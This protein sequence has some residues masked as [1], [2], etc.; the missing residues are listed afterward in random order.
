ML[1]FEHDLY[2][3][4]QMLQVLTALE[5]LELEPGRV[6]VVQ[7]DHYLANMTVD[8]IIPLLPKRRTA[9]AAIFQSARRNWERFTSSSPARSLR[10][11]GRRRDRAAASCAPRCSG[12]AR[13][14][15][16]RATGCRDRSVRRSMP[17]TRGRR[18]RKSCSRARRRAKRRFFLASAIFER[19][20]RISARGDGAL[21]E[22][23]EAPR[24]SRPRSGRRVIAGDADWLDEHP[25]DRW[26]GG[27]HLVRGNVT[28]WDEDAG[29]FVIELTQ[30]RAASRPSRL[31]AAKPGGDDDPRRV[32][33]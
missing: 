10:G 20:S 16:G 17:L 14:I 24:S 30:C 8:E 3:Q 9:T 25:I 29:R 28:R 1:W 19:C 31:C 21:I 6:S 7:T 32:K 2:D 13:S 26:I 5:E 33:Y 15:H 27:V 23:E 11:G 4:L 12:C 18:A 22:E